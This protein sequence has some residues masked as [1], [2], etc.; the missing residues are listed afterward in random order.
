MHLAR[1][2]SFFWLALGSFAVRGA[3]IAC[4]GP[5]PP[6]P[7]SG[8]CA[9]TAGSSALRIQADLLGPNGVI[10]NGQLIVGSDGLIACVG[11]DCSTH[12][13]YA[14]APRIECPDGVLSP[15]LS[16]AMSRST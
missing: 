8:V 1:R 12:P 6:A 11:C 7:P 4:P 14:T 5:V 9:V 16:A 2:L 15:G 13:D 10:G 3:D